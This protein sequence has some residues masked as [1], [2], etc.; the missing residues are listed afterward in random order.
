MGAGTT[1]D[2]SDEA[3]IRRTLTRYCQLLDDGRFDEWITVFTDDVDFRVMG[4]ALTGPEAVRA[5]IEPTQ[6]PEARGTHLISEPLIDLA[7][8]VG[9]AQATT[10][11]AFVSR[12]NRIEATGRYHDRF[13]RQDGVWRI[14]AREIVL[15]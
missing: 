3:G 10:D 15:R 1:A 12:K 13:R 6:Q 14:C 5:F 2:G 8:G 4:Q 9:E 7:D 11:F